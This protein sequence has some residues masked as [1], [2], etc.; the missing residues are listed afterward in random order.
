MNR[1]RGDRDGSAGDGD[2]ADAPARSA[3]VCVHGLGHV[4]LPTAAALAADGADVLGVDVDEAKV[5]RLRE[6]GPSNVDPDL[7]AFVRG[8]LAGSLRVSTRPAPAG[9]HVVCVPTPLAAGDEPGADLSMV[10]AA[11]ATVAD[12]LR[13]GDTVVLES[14]VPPGT[15]VGPFADALAES[16]LDPGTDFH[17]AYAP[18]TVTPGNVLAELRGNDRVVGGVTTESA[19]ATRDLYGGVTE[20]A[21][22]VAPSPT[23]AEFV[24]LFQNTYRDVN[25][26]LA[27]EFAR[28]AAEWGVDAREAIALANA[29]PRV[30]VHSP[31]PG[32]GGHCVP[33]DPWFLVAGADEAELK[34]VTHAREVN[35]GMADYVA[36]LVAD[37]LGGLDGARVA[38]CGVAYKPD[39]ADARNSPGRRVGEALAAGGAADVT[40]HDPFVDDDDVTADV[41]AALAGADAVAFAAG[42]RAYADLSPDRATAAMDGAVAVDAVGVLDRR[43]WRAAGVDLRVV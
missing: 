8:A 6:A 29:H 5:E 10:E 17:L 19:A 30:D 12:L 35:D 21:I 24:K 2:P 25:V 34:L 39:V 37:P 14:T 40:Y 23:A 9:V 1:H 11:G 41:D 33:V 20:G 43:A 36:G 31:G 28:A 16:G 38:V 26:G 18:E 22:R 3:D 27:N 42:H 15:T 4:G 7:E 32:V 13:A